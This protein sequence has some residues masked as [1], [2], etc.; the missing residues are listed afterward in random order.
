MKLT[1][2]QLMWC[3]TFYVSP[4][5]VEELGWD[6]FNS[7]AGRDTLAWMKA[8]KLIDDNGESTERLKAFVG[9]LCETPLPVM[10]WVRPE[11]S[12]SH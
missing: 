11:A 8:E 9:F 10:K 6:H 5:P 3:L 2:M 1:P 7:P 4:E 12:A